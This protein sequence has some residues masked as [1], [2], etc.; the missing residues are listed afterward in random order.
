[1]GP[2]AGSQVARGEFQPQALTGRG[3]DWRGT[4]TPSLSLASSNPAYGSPV[5]GFPASFISGP[6][7]SWN[8]FLRLYGPLQPWFDKSWG[9]REFEMVKE[10]QPRNTLE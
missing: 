9:L 2:K 4:K 10:E 6:G 7:K 3:E 8:T 5:P 1:M